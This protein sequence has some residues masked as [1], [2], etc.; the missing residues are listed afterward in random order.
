[1]TRSAW[2]DRP[3]VHHNVI[4]YH[5][6]SVIEIYCARGITGDQ[7]GCVTIFEGT[8]FVYIENRMFFGEIARLVKGIL[9]HRW[10]D[11]INTN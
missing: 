6:I 4:F 9:H 2:D 11:K 1:M 3:D 10:K 5:V 7:F 8:P